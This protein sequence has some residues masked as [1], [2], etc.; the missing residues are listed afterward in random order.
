MPWNQTTPNQTEPN[1]INITGIILSCYQK[2]SVFL[3]RFSFYNQMYI[4]LCAISPLYSL[5]YPY[6]C[7]LPIYAS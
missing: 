7:F 1:H 4:F 6:S 2:N 5:D 3:V